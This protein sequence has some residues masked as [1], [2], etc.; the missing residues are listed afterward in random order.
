[1]RRC[2]SFNSRCHESERKNEGGGKVDLPLLLI[3]KVCHLENCM[4]RCVYYATI[5]HF[6]GL[7][8]GTLYMLGEYKLDY[9]ILAFSPM[10]FVLTFYSFHI[11][12]VKIYLL[13]YR[14]IWKAQYK[15]RKK[16]FF[17]Q[18][19]RE[20]GTK[21]VAETHV[22]AETKEQDIR[23][24]LGIRN[25]YNDCYETMEDTLVKV[26]EVSSVNLSLLHAEDK[27]EFMV[28]MKHF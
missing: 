20:D 3:Q 13:E 16:Q 15:W 5:F 25:I 19:E 26:I 8:V 27:K 2:E 6:R 9:A 22:V 18:R 28:R 14:V 11:L 1:M 12:F 21:M 24:V 23:E 7:V 17:I 4:E 10:C